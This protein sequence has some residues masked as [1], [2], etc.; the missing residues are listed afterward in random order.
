MPAEDMQT[1]VPDQVA[2]QRHVEHLFLDCMSGLVELAWTDPDD[3]APRHANLFGID[4]LDELVEKAAAL[5]GERRN[6]YVGAALRKE[7]APPFGRS[8]GVDFL[9]ATALWADLDDAGGTVRASTR[10]RELG[11]PPTLVVV[12][13]TKPHQR[14]Q[15]W[16]RLD[17]PDAD[18]AHVRTMLG[19]LQLAFASDASVVDSIRLLRLGGSVAWPIK[20]GR[21]I[22]RTEV[23]TFDGSRARMYG[24]ARLE[25]AF[26]PKEQE[27]TD[28]PGLDIG[29]EF[30]GVDIDELIAAVLA[31]DRWHDNLLRLVGHWVGRGWSD[32]EILLQA[33]PLTLPGYRIEQTRTELATMI[34][35]ARAEV[36]QAGPRAHG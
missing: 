2:M 6:T 26:P 4:R 10:Y 28:A 18:A 21:V 5:N 23:I 30:E 33:A 16:W 19:A 20:N 1:P 7:N 36:E 31:G 22:E 14:A 24:M 25:A 29:G 35:G 32:G 8:N 11:V 34:A 12:T 15:L 13:G 9:A 3:G 17:E 27:R